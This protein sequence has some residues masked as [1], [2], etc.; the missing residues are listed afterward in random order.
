MRRKSMIIALACMAVGVMGFAGILAAENGLSSK[1]QDRQANVATE[2]EM[3]ITSKEIAP[4][5]TKPKVDN[6][7]KKAT[8]E[9]DN[10]V[11]KVDVTD[12]QPIELPGD[13]IEEEV[14]EDTVP[15]AS[16]VE[17]TLHFSEN[18]TLAW[19]V[20]GNVLL[21][22]SMDAT[23]YFPTLEQYRYNPAI[24][25]QGNVNDKVYVAAKGKITEILTN[26]ETG[27]TVIQDLGD[28][29][30]ACYGQLKDL[31]FAVG[32]MVDAGQVIG[33]VAEPT[34]YYSVEGSNVYFEILK[35]GVPVDPLTYLE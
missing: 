17:E 22:Y 11:S 29:Y 21:N 16:P 27:C 12:E 33:Y 32:D 10:S 28:G 30:T 25:I 34:K 19:P 3:E 35:D 23:T 7:E 8:V 5:T 26:E 1:G 6:V 24:V 9:E 2:Q 18:T 31:N 13:G 14:G 15:T 20:K 4:K